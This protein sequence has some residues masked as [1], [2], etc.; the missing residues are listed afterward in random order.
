MRAWTSTSGSTGTLEARLFSSCT[1]GSSTACWRLGGGCSLAARSSCE[2]RF[3]AAAAACVRS[4]V[5]SLVRLS[6][7]YV[8]L[9]T[10]PCP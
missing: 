4:W 6:K 1:S 5:A 3:C 9:A 7:L 2:T 8:A 10:V